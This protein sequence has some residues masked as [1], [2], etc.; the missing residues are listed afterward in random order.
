MKDD[1]TGHFILQKK[2]VDFTHIQR[3][4]AGGALFLLGNGFLDT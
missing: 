4:A 1:E 3:F 2:G